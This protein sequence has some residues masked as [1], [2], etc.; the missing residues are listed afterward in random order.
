[1]KSSTNLKEILKHILKT[2]PESKKFPKSLE[3]MYKITLKNTNLTNTQRTILLVFFAAGILT[4]V[5]FVTMILGLGFLILISK[6]HLFALGNLA[7]MEQ[8]WHA[9]YFN[10]LG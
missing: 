9:I 6:E 7:G 8:L 4:V 1:M 3:E 2:T 10:P 5:L